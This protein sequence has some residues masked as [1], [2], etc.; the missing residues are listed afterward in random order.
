M[1]ILG[2]TRV[3]RDCWL[4]PG[5]EGKRSL[6]WKGREM[7]PSERGVLSTFEL[8]PILPLLT[9]TEKAVDLPD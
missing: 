3:P 8:R 7:V 4:A 6:H 1:C 5:V 9:A 2:S